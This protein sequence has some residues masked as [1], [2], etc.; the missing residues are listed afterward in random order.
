M[1]EQNTET[2]TPE[3]VDLSTHE[4]STIAKLWGKVKSEEPTMWALYSD[5]QK[6]SPPSNAEIDDVIRTSEDEEVI[7]LRK[8][9]EAA[10]TRLRNAKASAKDYV[11]SG[12]EVKPE[13]EV[14]ALK[15]EF[16]KSATKV[17]TLIGLVRDMAEE[18]DIEGV[19][20]ELK[21]YSF[22]T[23]RGVTTSATNTSTEGGPRPQVKA[24]EVT[25]SGKAAKSY[26]K[27]SFAATYMGIKT[28]ELY[29]AWMAASGADKWQDVKEA[30]TFLIGETTS[31]TI[32]PKV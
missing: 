31:V 3:K 10:E 30:T 32:V 1:T 15:D 21:R 22:P 26:D 17:K 29:D 2:V 6:V 11:L 9:V 23:L 8:A 20:D 18:L 16:R 5:L 14:N 4:D 7:K 25:K 28:P 27:L 13:E 19:E 12:F 24:I